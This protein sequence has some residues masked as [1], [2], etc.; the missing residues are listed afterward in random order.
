[1]Y[2]NRLTTYDEFGV[3]LPMGREYTLEFQ[4]TAILAGETKYV[5]TDFYVRPIR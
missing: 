5:D 1:M 4:N 2:I 3:Y